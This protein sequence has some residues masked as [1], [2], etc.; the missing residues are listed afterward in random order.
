MARLLKKNELGNV[1]GG[2]KFGSSQMSI[3]FHDANEEQDFDAFLKNYENQHG[4]VDTIT[5]E[6]ID[7][8]QQDRMT[9]GLQ[10]YN[11]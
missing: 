9:R 5:D 6:I 8:F 3:T 2:I 7:A 4:H 10:I 11:D 1:S